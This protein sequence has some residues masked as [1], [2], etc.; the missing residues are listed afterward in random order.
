M[1]PKILVIGGTGFIGQNLISFLSKRK[2]N[3][4]SISRNFPK[5][6]LK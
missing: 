2:F 4:T 1:K 5:K 3:I 6:N